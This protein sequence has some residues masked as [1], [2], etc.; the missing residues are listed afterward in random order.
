MEWN[1]SASS[2]ISQKEKVYQ[3]R[4]NRETTH[5]N[6]NKFMSLTA[7]LKFTKQWGRVRRGRGRLE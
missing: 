7:E 2:E 3:T 4:Y 5:R 1:W 6:I